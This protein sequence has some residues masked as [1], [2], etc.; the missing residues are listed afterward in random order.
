MG[1]FQLWSAVSRNIIGCT[2]H[3]T[4]VRGA[5][6]FAYLKRDIS[7]SLV[8]KLQMCLDWSSQ[9][10]LR[11][12]PCSQISQISTDLCILR[13]GLQNPPY[14]SFRSDPFYILVYTKLAP[15]QF[16][17]FREI[18]MVKEFRIYQIHCAKWVLGQRCLSLRLQSPQLHGKQMPLMHRKGAILGRASVSSMELPRNSPSI[19]ILSPLGL[20]LC[21]THRA[22]T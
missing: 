5:H 19:L 8:T 22:S 14:L 2:P 7:A 3:C 11:V 17:R 9:K 13:F 20:Q 18:R 10:C 1:S 21:R 4:T 16:N 15:S 12:V 6:I